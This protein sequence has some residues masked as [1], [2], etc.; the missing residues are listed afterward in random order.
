MPRPAARPAR[1]F[2]RRLAHPHPR[3]LATLADA[4][5]SPQAWEGTTKIAGT[6]MPATVVGTVGLN[7]VVTHG[8]DLARAVGQPFPAGD[9]TIA[10]CL[11]FIEPMSQPGAASNRAPAFGPTLAAPDSAS[12][13]DRLDRVDRPRPCL[14]SG[15]K[16][17]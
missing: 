15:L 1:R 6:E 9:A 5:A 13:I 11:E 4:W 14:D 7:E 2:G 12:N 8:W 17:G 16:Q 3:D 10:G